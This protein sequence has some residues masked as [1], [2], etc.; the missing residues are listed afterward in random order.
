M[1]PILPQP[2]ASPL[3]QSTAASDV[4]GRTGATNHTYIRRATWN[5]LKINAKHK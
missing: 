3:C 1:I 4:I 2:R 5:C